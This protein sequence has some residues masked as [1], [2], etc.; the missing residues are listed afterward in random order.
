M[1]ISVK[2]I[3]GRD[4]CIEAHKEESIA[5]LKQTLYSSSGIEPSQ[6]ALLLLGNPVEDTMKIRDMPI[7]SD[8]ILIPIL[9]GGEQISI[10]MATGK[11]IHVEVDLENG[12]VSDLKE[13][14]KKVCGVPIPEQKLLFKKKVLDNR[15]AIKDYEIEKGSVIILI[16]VLEGGIINH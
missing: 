3:T 7:N 8:I 15:K 5:E 11:T 4:F 2:S 6:Q 14:I 1:K 9:S 16:P 12:K 10:K 13:A